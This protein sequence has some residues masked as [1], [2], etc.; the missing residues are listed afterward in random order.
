LPPEDVREGFSLIKIEAPK[1]M[2]SLLGYIERNYIGN[3]EKSA[4]FPIEF[5]NVYARVLKV[6][7]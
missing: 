1:T 4:R 6:K 5:W 2:S 7:E 3:E